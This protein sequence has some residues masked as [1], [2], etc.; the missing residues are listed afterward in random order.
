MGLGANESALPPNKTSRWRPS[1][2]GYTYILTQ[3]RHNGPKTIGTNLHGLGSRQLISA[4][5]RRIGPYCTRHTG[6]LSVQKLVPLGADCS[7][8][9]W[10]FDGRVSRALSGSQQPLFGRRDNQLRAV[11]RGRRCFMAVRMTAFH[12]HGAVNK[13]FRSVRAAG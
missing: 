4:S 11:N 3:W 9:R 8:Q 12:G 6:P 5:C 1:Q 10:I 7:S 2:Y 13:A